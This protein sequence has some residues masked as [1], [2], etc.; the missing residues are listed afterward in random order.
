MKGRPPKPTAL[1]RVTGNPGKRP[2]NED[3]PQLPEGAPNCPDSLKGLAK[4][5]WFEYVEILSKM[6]VLTEADGK[7]LYQLCQ[8]HA[9][10]QSWQ[11]AIKKYGRMVRGASGDLKVNPAARMLKEVR[12]QIKAYLS[13]F[14]LTPAARSKVKVVPKKK[15]TDTTGARHFA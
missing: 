4:T 13:E 14:G 8:L 12:A 7:A 9:D 15:E 10:E 11:N 1:K 6:G 5:M 3:E 2:L